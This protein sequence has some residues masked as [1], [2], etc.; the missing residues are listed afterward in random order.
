MVAVSANEASSDDWSHVTTHTFVVIVS[1]KSVGQNRNF[2][3]VELAIFEINF[4]KLTRH[5]V[6]DAI[7]LLAGFFLLFQIDL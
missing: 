6:T 1:C 5:Q 3:T 2:Y 7:L 4:V